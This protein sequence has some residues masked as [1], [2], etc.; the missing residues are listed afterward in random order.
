MQ[1]ARQQSHPPPCNKRRLHH[2]HAD[3]QLTHASAQHPLCS[4]FKTPLIH[5]LLKHLGPC[6]QILIK[7]PQPIARAALVLPW[8]LH[9]DPIKATTTNRKSCIGVIEHL[10]STQ[11]A[12]TTDQATQAKH[13][14]S[15]AHKHA[16]FRA[17]QAPYHGNS[18]TIRFASAVHP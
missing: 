14:R 11:T 4:A 18:I 16:L 10:S 8:T 15:A 12:H 17:P 7:P 9:T 2:E 13:T 3:R 6:T 1:P 5:P